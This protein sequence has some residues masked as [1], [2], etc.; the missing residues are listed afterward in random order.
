MDVS[1]ADTD[2][3]T[4]ACVGRPGSEGFEDIDAKTYAAWGVDYLKVSVRDLLTLSL[5]RC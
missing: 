2:R 5:P 1:V 4:A 3:G